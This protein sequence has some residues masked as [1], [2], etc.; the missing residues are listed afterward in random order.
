MAAKSPPADADPPSPA[1]PVKPV[2][3]FHKPKAG[4]DFLRHLGALGEA[5]FSIPEAA[6]ALAVREDDLRELLQR[7]AARLAFEQGRLRTLLT[8]RRAQFDLARTNATM[9]MF[10]GRA[11]FD[12]GER[13]EASDEQDAEI[14]G[15][16]ERLRAKIAAL[17]AA[18]RARDAAAGS[19][20]SE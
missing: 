12:Q 1:S 13:R 5:L 2:R 17:A 8:L 11:H 18:R 15:A 9:A 19:G 10:L 16:A 3:R 7:D 4:A 20:D 14:E 6:L